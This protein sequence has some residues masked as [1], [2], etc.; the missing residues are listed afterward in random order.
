M[1]LTNFRKSLLCLFAIIIL[2]VATYARFV[3]LHTPALNEHGDPIFRSSFM[4]LG[5][6]IRWNGDFTCIFPKAGPVNWLFL[7]MDCIWRWLMNFPPSRIE[8]SEDY[9]SEYFNYQVTKGKS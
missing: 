7:P 2:Y 5:S 8:A 6:S 3:D 1:R 9:W 4:S